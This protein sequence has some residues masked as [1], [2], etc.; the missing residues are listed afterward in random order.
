MIKIISLSRP[1]LSRNIRWLYSSYYYYGAVLTMWKSSTGMLINPPVVFTLMRQR[2]NNTFS[3]QLA[4]HVWTSN[5]IFTP[6]N[7]NLF[8]LA[9][10]SPMFQKHFC[11][12]IPTY[13]N[14]VATYRTEEIQR[15]P[16]YLDSGSP[17]FWLA[18]MVVRTPMG[19][20]ISQMSL[21]SLPTS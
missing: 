1:S 14:T 2:W 17:L 15:W 9:A 12:H 7:S 10:T 21:I 19:L 16:R 8:F 5:I 18:N 4:L 11:S 13:I 3:L 20:V 6:G